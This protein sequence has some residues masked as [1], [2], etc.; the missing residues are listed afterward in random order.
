VKP[1]TSAPL[2]ALAACIAGGALC[3]WIGTPLPWM[4]GPLF[5]MALF[6]VAGADLSSP[7]FG[8]ESGQLIIGAALGLY[9]TPNVAREVLANWHVLIAAAVL[10]TALGWICGL[11]LARYTGVDRTTAFFS[12]V[13]GGATEMAI[14]GERM[15]AKPDRIALAQSL[16]IL[17]VVIIIPF[18]LTLADVH[19]TDVYFQV[20]TAPNAWG[21]AQLLAVGIVA[22]G[23]LAWLRV[24]NAFMLGPLGVTIAF[25][26]G[27]QHFSSMP[28]A[29][30]NVGQL[31]IGCTLGARFE[32]EFVKKAPQFMF[33]V[34]LSI[35]LAILLA[36]IGGWLLARLGGLAVPTMVL[37]TAPGGIAEMCITAKVLQLGVPLVTAA[38]VTRVL[39][40]VTTTAPLFRLARHYT[41]RKP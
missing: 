10:A 25:T 3:A 22:G 27:E 38:H 15:G 11:F 34:A 12:C 20:A 23:L 18:S 28:G 16:R 21:L 24:P 2:K 39:I 7:R 26:V 1:E 13:P 8:R 29:L 32:R 31:L 4:V 36:G 9:F 40:L 14:L 6:K 33:V 41:R 19:G 37:A 35:L 17:M 5:A 30:S